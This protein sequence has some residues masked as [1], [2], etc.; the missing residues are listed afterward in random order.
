M[1]LR[2]LLIL[3]L[4]LPACTESDAMNLCTL[5]GSAP[6]GDAPTDYTAHANCMGAWFMNTSNDSETDRSG[7]GETLTQVDGSM[8]T[9]AT[10]PSGYSGTSRDFGGAETLQHADGGS[11]DISGTGGLT[12]AAWVNIDDDGD[13]VIVSKYAATDNNRQYQL[14]HRDT[15]DTVCG[16]IG[17]STSSYCKECATTTTL[18]GEYHHIA[19]NWDGTTLGIYVDGVLEGGGLSC[20]QTM[21]NGGQ[22]FAIGGYSDSSAGLTGDIDEVI[23]F[24]VGMGATVINEL[25]N[26]GIDG[27]KGGND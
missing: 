6:S 20:S 22:T 7:E 4:L 16:Y 8:P 5:G 23:I 24:N 19:L 9:S 3:L 21:N 1:K 11:T 2:Y 15:E 10:V 17:Y 26:Y 13:N 14:L 25:M 12:I 18:D 27:T